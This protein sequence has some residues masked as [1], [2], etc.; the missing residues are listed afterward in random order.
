VAADAQAIERFR[1]E[2][3]A[4]AA[5]NHPNIC[6]IYEIGE[7]EGRWFIAMELLE[8]QTLK[9]RRGGGR[10]NTGELL[11]LTIQIADVSTALKG[12]QFHQSNGTQV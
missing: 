4:A 5:L 6:S 9:H 1:R 2:A 7:H 10:L 12:N 8:G 11:E 3:R